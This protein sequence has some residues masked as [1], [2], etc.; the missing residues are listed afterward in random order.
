MAKTKIEFFPK[1]FS[2]PTHSKPT[3]Q[4][5]Q[6]PA[7]LQNRTLLTSQLFIRDR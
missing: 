2:P 5:S 6:Q 3:G 7:A 4:R 1:K